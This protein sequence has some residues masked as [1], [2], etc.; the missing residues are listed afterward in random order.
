MIAAARLVVSRF[1]ASRKRLRAEPPLTYEEARYHERLD[2]MVVRMSATASGRETCGQ[3]PAST[4]A[5]W[6]PSL[7]AAACSIQSVRR[8]RSAVGAM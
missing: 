7:S 6:T 8:V 2:R 5:A 1:Q 4:V 3:W